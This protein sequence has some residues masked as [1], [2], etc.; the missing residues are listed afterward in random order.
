MADF[1]IFPVEILLDRRVWFL[2]WLG[3]GADVPDHILS[4]DGAIASFS[5]IEMLADTLQREG[6]HL[7]SRYAKKYDLDRVQHWA[8]GRSEDLSEV[9]VLDAWNLFLD[10]AACLPAL[11]SA[12]LD[13]HEVNLGLH[14]R[15]SLVAVEEVLLDGRSTVADVSE[16]K[17]VLSAGLSLVRRGMRDVL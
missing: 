3:N 17:P 16:A 4:K 9:D 6:R 14:E 5:S 11:A 7:E 1:E 8:D 12:F 2:A 10:V 15:I 13:L